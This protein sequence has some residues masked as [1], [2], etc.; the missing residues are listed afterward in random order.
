MTMALYAIADLHLCTND[1]ADKSMEVFGNSWADYITRIEQNWR[2][3]ITDADTV[4]IPGDISWALSLEDAISDLKFIDALPGKKIL[5]KGNHD[6][7]WSTMRKHE[8]LFEKQEIKSISF[9]F[10]NAHE[11]D[12]HIIVGTRGWYNDED[13][14]NIPSGTDFLK[15]TRREAQRLETS[16]KEGLKLK[17]QSPE[18][19]IIAFL[20]FPPFWNGKA[21]D[22]LIE[23]LNRY[24]IKRV[25]YGHIH[26]NY[27]VSPTFTHGDIEMSII[28]A[29]YLKFT[30]KLIK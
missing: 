18:K 8:A 1:I 11:S 28:S 13:A 17:E 25:F 3:L 6:F 10:N 30:P 4:V 7:W 19:E 5:A 21:S 26:G 9:L 27:T 29:D 16:I 2:R 15:L 24:G 23:V 14:S 20:H 12:E 22:T